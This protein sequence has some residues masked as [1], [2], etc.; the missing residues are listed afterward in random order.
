MKDFDFYPPKYITYTNV[1]G[2]RVESGQAIKDALI[3]QIV[4]T[5]RFEDCLRNAV[6]DNLLTELFE[7]GPSKVLAGFAKR[8]DKTL[9]VTPFSEFE[10]LPL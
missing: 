7:C 1:T 2:G 8:I 4:S 6:N 10:D 3:K 5:V 9:K